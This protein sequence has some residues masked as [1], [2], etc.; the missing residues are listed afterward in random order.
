M[1]INDKI[2][3][4]V[5]AQMAAHQAHEAATR[6]LT[7]IIA[8]AVSGNILGPSIQIQLDNLK[9]NAQV[10]MDAIKKIEELKC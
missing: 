2:Q 8:D 4:L 10:L 5:S 9:L 6:A 1:T 7:L 3:Q